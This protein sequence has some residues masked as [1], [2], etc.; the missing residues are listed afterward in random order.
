MLRFLIAQLGARPGRVAALGLGILVA[1][2][3]FTLLTAA[4]RT[5]ELRVRGTVSGNFRTAYDILVRPRGSATPLERSAGLVRSN[6]LSGIYGGI[7]LRQWSTI[8]HVPGIEVAAPVANVGYVFPWQK[9]RIGI[10][11][12]LT[13]APAQLYR[14]KTWW[15][16]IDGG[17]YPGFVWYVYYTRRGR[18]VGETRWGIMG[19]VDSRRP[20]YTQP[21]DGFARPL[22]AQG[23]FDPLQRGELACFAAG[24]KKNSFNWGVRDPSF[25]DFVGGQGQAQ[26]PIA[27]AAID[28]SSEAKL[29]DLDR[30]MVAGRYLRPIDAMALRRQPSGRFV[31]PLVPVIASSQSYVGEQLEVEVERLHVPRGT[32][33]PEALSAG[34]CTTGNRP[35]PE[36]VSPPKGASYRTGREFLERLRGTVIDTRTKPIAPFYRRLLTQTQDWAPGSGVLQTEGIWTVSPVRYRSLARGHLA[37][38]PTRNPASVWQTTVSALSYTQPPT[39]NADLQFRR[40]QQ[41]VTLNQTIESG[42][43]TPAMRVVGEFDPRKLPGFSPLSR[44]PLETYYPPILEPAD[45]ASSQELH[46]QNYLPTQNLGGYVAQPPLLLT[47]IAALKRYFL[48][49]RYFGGI[50]K[51]VRQ[52]PLSVVRVKVKGVTGPDAVSQA[53]IRLVAGQIHARTGLDVDITAGSSPHPLLISLPRGRFGSPPLLL[54]EGWSKK[55]V[56]LTFLRALDRKSLSLLALILVT[57]AFFLANGAFAAVR[58]RRSEIGTLLTL[59]WSRRSIFLVVLGEL[60]LVGL[61]A[62]LLGTGIALATATIFSLSLSLLQSLLVLPISLALALTAGLLPAWRAARG[63]PLDAI[64]PAVS[65]GRST[66]RVRNVAGMAFVN[67]R[68][69]PSRTLAAVLGLA[70]GVAALTFLLAIERAFQGAVV[71]TLLGNAISVQVR[72]TDFAAVGL[73]LGLASLSIADVLYLNLRERQ[74][75]LVTL[76]TFGWPDPVLRRLVALEALG[77]GL[78][79]GCA[80]ALVGS[81]IAGLV[82]EVGSA[83][84]A[85]AAL[86]AAAGGTAAALL[87]SLPQLSRI[88]RLIPP[89]VL[90]ADE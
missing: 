49:P 37:P 43:L 64:R 87:A 17:R 80:G 40:L 68:R 54:R 63:A 76:R 86:L 61:V 58:G 72:G 79:G 56:S 67:L 66:R 53:R 73:T 21:C 57:C 35:C 26:F 24:Q 12:L 30:A 25:N 83:H 88:Q 6:Y 9:V 82:F 3:A 90:A 77:F 55:E 38:L 2:V 23:P 18:F 19:E 89:T 13:N 41:R 85:A 5:S 4:A 32:D 34:A 46:G 62:G 65:L 74:V 29:V 50:P 47:T 10:K 84:L 39:E 81:L 8:A 48:N 14:I 33:V 75:E 42:V 22:F 16:A 27:L 28:P 44:V 15:R 11:G 70:L 69:V 51:A 31:V 45:A 59:G 71:G 20:G 78:L 7:T 52:A 36:T 1:A 60:V